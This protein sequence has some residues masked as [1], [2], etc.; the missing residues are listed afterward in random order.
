MADEAPESVVEAPP[1]PK[2][3]PLLPEEQAV[4]TGLIAGRNAVM[5]QIEGYMV[6]VASRLGLA[7]N[8]VLDANINTGLITL[9][10]D[11]PIPAEAPAKE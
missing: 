5:E 11:A 3:V 9:A 2:T 7:R 10:S 1:K 4:L 8:R 6:R